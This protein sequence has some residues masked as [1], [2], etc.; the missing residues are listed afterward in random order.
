MRSTSPLLFKRLKSS[1]NVLL[2]DNISDILII[3]TE[4]KEKE[5]ERMKN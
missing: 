2:V 3:I 5:K 4:I 1:I